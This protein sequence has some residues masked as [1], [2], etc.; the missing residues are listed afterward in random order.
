MPGG[1]L[2]A[3]IERLEWLVGRVNWLTLGL[4]KGLS[5]AILAVMTA[6]IVC[7]VFFRYV[8]NDAII[9]S[10]E[11]AKFLMVWMTFMAAPIGLKMGAH[12][13]IEVLLVRLEGR[14]R[15]LLQV[16]IYM[17]IISLMVVFVKE[18][19]FLTNNAKIQRASTVDVSI[20]YVYAAMPIGCAVMALVAFEFMLGA[21]KGIIDPSRVEEPEALP[22]MAE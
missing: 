14:W 15:A 7:A 4:L 6:I 11:I 12:V 18:G 13:A 17:A 3:G 10:E 20:F 16:A 21:I 22:P 5:I 2:I 19:M 9:W 8:L 1:R